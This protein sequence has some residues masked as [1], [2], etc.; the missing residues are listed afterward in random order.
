K[1]SL[2]NLKSTTMKPYI[3]ECYTSRRYAIFFEELIPIQCVPPVKYCISIDGY[4]HSHPYNFGKGCANQLF[5]IECDKISYNR[6]QSQTSQM[7]ND[8]KI[9]KGI[10]RCCTS[11]LCNIK[12]QIKFQKFIIINFILIN[13]YYLTI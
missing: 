5:S 12:Y 9:M 13:Y 2:S 10:L 7:Y 6:L 8:D 3:D 11:D 4:T 1:T